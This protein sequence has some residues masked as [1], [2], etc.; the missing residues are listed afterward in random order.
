[1]GNPRR[2]LHRSLI[3]LL[4]LSFQQLSAQPTDF[5]W[6]RGGGQFSA[7][8]SLAVS[9]DGTFFATWETGGTITIREAATGYILHRLDAPERGTKLV[10]VKNDEQLAAAGDGVLRIWN[11]PDLS[12]V[13]YELPRG[14]IAQLEYYPESERLGMIANFGYVR[15][16]DLESG[17]VAEEYRPGEF[18]SVECLIDHGRSVV[19]VD[20]DGNARRMR[21]DASQPNVA[22]VVLSYTR[23]HTTFPGTILASTPDSTLIATTANDGFVRIIDMKLAR[24]V[25]TATMSEIEGYDL[26]VQYYLE[27]GQHHPIVSGVFTPDGESLILH[28]DMDGAIIEID[29]KSGSVTRSFDDGFRYNYGYT[30]DTPGVGI[31]ESIVRFPGNSSSLF[32]AVYQ[33]VFDYGSGRTDYYLAQFHSFDDDRYAERIDYTPN[34]RGVNQIVVAPDGTSAISVAGM[35]RISWSL[36]E[37]THGGALRMYGPL[38]GMAVLSPE[39]SARILISSSFVSPQMAETVLYAEPGFGLIRIP[40]GG[41]VPS[42]GSLAISPGGVYALSIR[43][44]YRSREDFYELPVS[45]VRAATFSFDTIHLGFASGDSVIIWNCADERIER[46]FIPDESATVLAFDRNGTKL[47]CGLSNGSIALYDIEAGTETERFTGHDSVISALSFT[48]AGT[49][50]V[51][52]GTDSTVRWWNV[53]SGGDN[54]AYIYPDFGGLVTALAAT[55]DG[56]YVVT[57][58][59]RGSIMLWKGNKHIS[60]VRGMQPSKHPPIDL[61]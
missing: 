45:S 41:A 12:S 28:S 44:I 58:T 17:T 61:R 59:D 39:G 13:R 43:T 46:I 23:N 27:W 19:I 1:M 38:S 60:D 33:N 54:A 18:G 24:V 50:L 37:G 9:S 29:V 32:V 6:E 36:P 10:F 26:N 53:G 21:L 42:A 2:F 15:I 56:R 47:A 22:H 52:A 7:T 51:S 5:I 55:P 20:N 57:G 11:M 3:L 31:L 30:S 35:T 25:S 34:H 48:R 4:L 16:F 40:I 14:T 8:S 49:A